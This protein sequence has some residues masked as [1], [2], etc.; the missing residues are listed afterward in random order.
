ML[1]ID[2]DLSE[3]GSH[4]IDD[5]IDC[6]FSYIG[7]L[8]RD[9]IQE[10]I[11]QEIKDTYDL[12]YRFLQ[13]TQPSDYVIKL[14]NSMQSYKPTHV[15]SSPYIIQ[16]ID[17]SMIPDL[18]SYLTPSNLLTLYKNKSVKTSKKEKWYGTDYDDEK[19]STELVNRWNQ[20]LNAKSTTD[21]SWFDKLFLPKPNPFIPKDFQIRCEVEN[22]QES[23]VVLLKK[24]CDGLIM[25]DSVYQS[26]IKD[27]KVSSTAA[28]ESSDAKEENNDGEA[29]AEDE[30]EEESS[31]PQTSLDSSKPMQLFSGKSLQTW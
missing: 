31:A 1:G 26:S 27:E 20:S 7:M 4:H 5:I 6:V 12:N 10:W 8:K 19:F 28:A 30:E 15:V 16:K 11:A 18:L 2:I 24:S 25:D 22:L 13:K 3:E 21:S 23:N 29:E 14:A 17:I 9:G